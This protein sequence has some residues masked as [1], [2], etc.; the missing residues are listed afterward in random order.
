LLFGAGDLLAVPALSLGP[1]STEQPAS[2]Q[3]NPFLAHLVY[4]TTTEPCRLA[5]R[6]M[7]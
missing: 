4:G 1:S 5:I 6:A 2:P 7:L 3:T